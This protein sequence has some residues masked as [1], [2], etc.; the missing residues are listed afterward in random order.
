VRRV[1]V[2]MEP[3]TCTVRIRLSDVS[4]RSG[5]FPGR[6]AEE[7]GLVRD[8]LGWVVPMRD[9]RTVQTEGV[10]CDRNG[11]VRVFADLERPI[12]GEIFEGL[13]LAVD[14]PA[15]LEASD[16]RRAPETDLLL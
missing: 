1:L 5:S 11:D 3:R 7:G 8:V 13:H 12:D 14:R 15:D 16:L 4:G 2:A 9:R 6:A 10:R